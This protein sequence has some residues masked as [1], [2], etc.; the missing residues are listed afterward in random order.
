VSTLAG[1]GI[2]GFADGTGFQTQFQY[3]V[4]L[5]IDPE[6]N[7]Y[8]A[9]NGSHKIRKI[10]RQAGGGSRVFGGTLTTT[11]AG[12]GTAGYFD[13]PALQAMFYNPI[14][15]ACDSNK[16]LYIADHVNNRIRKI[17]KQG[18]VISLAGTGAAGYADGMG[19]EAKFNNPNGVAL[20]SDGNLYV[21][22]YSNN[23]VRKVTPQGVVFT[24]AGTGVAGYADGG[25][26]VAMFNGPIGVAVDGKGNVYVAD[27]RNHRIRKI[28]QFGL[29]TTIAGNGV[30][31]YADGFGDLV[32]FNYPYALALDSD[33]NLFVA[34]HGNHRIRVIRKLSI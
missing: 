6:G 17:T 9:D 5:T 24:V 11:Y 32:K 7:V 27:H 16:N 15:V 30:G 1:S 4:G 19:S 12:K 23:R 28:S 20:D 31:G 34:D 2:Q 21:A 22:D 3:P 13:G 33:K 14:A 8:V 26:D 25:K 10:S 18:I 29:V